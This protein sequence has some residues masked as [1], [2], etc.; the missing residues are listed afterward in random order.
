MHNRVCVLVLMPLLIVVLYHRT[1]EQAYMIAIC[2]QLTQS[3]YSMQNCQS[4]SC[5]HRFKT[6]N[7]INS[8]NRSKETRNCVQ[9]HSEIPPNL[10]VK[11]GIPHILMNLHVTPVNPQSLSSPRNHTVSRR[12][13]RRRIEQM[14]EVAT[15]TLT[16]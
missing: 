7:R 8:S 16:D 14:R 11:H 13:L 3:I 10:D 2:I 6:P 5:V 4:V 9:F 1:I 15:R 12:R